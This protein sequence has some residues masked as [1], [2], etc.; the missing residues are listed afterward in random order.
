MDDDKKLEEGK[1][2]IEEKTEVIHQSKTA[3]FNKRYGNYNILINC[4]KNMFDLLNQ[5]F[6]TR[7]AKIIHCTSIIY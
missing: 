4:S 7:V 1:E 6:E 3:L 2:E 5:F